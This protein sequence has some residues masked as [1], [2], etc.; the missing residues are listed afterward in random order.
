MDGLSAV[1][2]GIAVFQLA[3]Q[4]AESF[5]KICDFWKS[6]EEAPE[7]IQA[8]SGDLNLL[9]SVLIKIAQETQHVEPD[10]TLIA[11]LNGCRVKVKTLTT[12]LNE[13]EPGFASK[14]LRIRKWTAFK[15]VLKHRELTKFQE[16][17]ERLKS[18]LLL[19]QQNEF[20]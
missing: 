14:S 1:A 20:R 15:A 9:S 3:V 11:A 4:L 19:V 12:L 5:K 6:I 7:E 17:L 18:T 8:I 2:S 13:I 10:T 16:A